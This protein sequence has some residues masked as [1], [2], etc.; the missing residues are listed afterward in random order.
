MPATT[1]PAA[2]LALHDRETRL[3]ARPDGPGVV[4]EHVGR[5]V[6][7]TGPAHSWNGVLWSGFTSAAEADDAIAA[8]IVHYTARGLSFEWK[9][10]AHDEPADLGERLAAAGFTAEP[11]ET[12]MAAEIDALALTGTVPDG[13]RVVPV[14]DAAGVDQVAEV[15]ERAFGDDASRLRRQ[16]L[17]ALAT[18]PDTIV[19]VL[20]LA[21]DAPVGAA[22]M[23][24]TP[25]TSFAGLWGGGTVPEWRGRGVYRALIAHRARVAAARGYR[26]LHVDASPRSHPILRRLG[27][28]PLTVTTPYVYGPSL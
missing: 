16:L 17:D 19:A 22:R 2:L 10:Y 24:L 6:R 11:D 23:E 18:T 1:A 8:Q 4:V 20:A 28:T 27:F 21:G 14:T 25:G 26:I 12:L 13:I 3:G 7:R 9:L 5:V 15:H